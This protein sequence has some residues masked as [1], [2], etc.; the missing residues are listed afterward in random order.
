M[1]M[2]DVGAQALAAL[3]VVALM[4][5]QWPISFRSSSPFPVATE[6]S[7]PPLQVLYFKGHWRPAFVKMAPLHHHF[8]L[9]GW[10]R[11][12]LSNAGGSSPC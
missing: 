5:N 3:G 11:H 12:R 2:G 4:T 9:I 8:R 6:L 1:F 7:R 10:A